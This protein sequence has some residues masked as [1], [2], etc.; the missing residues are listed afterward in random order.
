MKRRGLGKSPVKSQ[1]RNPI[2]RKRRKAPTGPVSIADLQ[3]Q[4][5]RRTRLTNALVWGD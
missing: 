1:G 2:L 4:L 3:E 5:D